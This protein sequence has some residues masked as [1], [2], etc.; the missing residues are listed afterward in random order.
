MKTLT[1]SYRT[2]AKTSPSGEFEAV[3]SAFGVVDSYGTRM[4]QGAFA[5]SI[6]KKLPKVLFHHEWTSGVGVVTEAEELPAG[7]ERL[8]ENIREYGGLW[9]KGKLNTETQRGSDLLSDMKFGIYDEWSVG[10]EVVTERA[11]D[12]GVIEFQKVN[13]IEVS[14]VLVGANPLTATTNIR[15]AEDAD[16]QLRAALNVIRDHAKA[17]GNMRIREG[18]K[19]SGAMRNRLEG[20][21]S[22]LQDAAKDISG[23]LEDTAPPDK[24]D[25]AKLILKLRGITQ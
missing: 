25:R 3:V 16:T 7:D 15:S 10:F 2:N 11:A 13:L 14:P 24:S 9:V 5:E 12:D 4:L 23:I 17:H 18:R 19:L 20:I 22:I 8:P 1:R 21:V 6:E